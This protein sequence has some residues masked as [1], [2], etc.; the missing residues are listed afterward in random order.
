VHA[1]A[2][3]SAAAL[4][5]GGLV[6]LGTS[7]AHAA[8]RVHWT[9][10]SVAVGATAKAVV[11]P[12]SRPAGTRL[13]LQRKDLDGWHTA[14]RT[15]R[16]T[17][18][19]LVLQVPTDQLGTFRFR[20][21]A[22]D[23]AEVRSA[24]EVERVR[25][26]PSYDP[27]GATADHGFLGSRRFRWNSCGTI[28]WAFNPDHAPRKA[29]GQIRTTIRKAHQATGLRFEYVGRTD[30][31]PRLRPHTGRYKV[32]VGWRTP[33]SFGYFGNHPGRVGVGGASWHSGYEEA[34]GTRVNRAWSGRLILNAR[35][36]K[37]L[38]NGYGRG[39][40][41]GD[42][43]LHEFGHVLG[44]GHAKGEKQL[45]YP[46]MTK[47]KARWGAGDLAGLRKL[48]SARGCLDRVSGRVHGD[49]LAAL[50]R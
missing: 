7:S 8:P 44:L 49:E 35:Y 37:D 50:T 34:D 42:V 12:R 11:S 9:D 30:E 26:R 25:V 33:R 31:R 24:S 21:A 48:G 29:L 10:T 36:N 43:I 46:Q 38:R 23:G 40:T 45:M 41:W 4:V 18:R 5:T 19:G 14:D 22:K 17:D 2:L 28:T 3:L 27:A 13:V 1:G 32:I 20:V 16:R 15:A 47:R 39:Y 6:V